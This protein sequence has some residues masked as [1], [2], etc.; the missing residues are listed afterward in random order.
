M[1]RV[2]RHW[3]QV[4]KVESQILTQNQAVPD[5]GMV[6]GELSKQHHVSPFWTGVIY[7]ALPRKD[8]AFLWLERAREERAPWMMYVKAL[9]WF[10]N[11]RADPRYYRLLQ[12]MNIPI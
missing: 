5:D 8:D 11:L 9:P 10:D 3:T 4:L 2:L 6:L 7:A 12:R 1:R